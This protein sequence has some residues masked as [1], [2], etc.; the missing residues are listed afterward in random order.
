MS[1]GD[2][3]IQKP[4]LLEFVSTLRVGLPNFHS[5]L[6]A[7]DWQ[8]RQSGAPSKNAEMMPFSLE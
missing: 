2:E 8:G 4:C 6:V 1:L 7:H 3:G 5:P